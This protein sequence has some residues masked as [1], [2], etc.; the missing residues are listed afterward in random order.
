MN[1]SKETIFKNEICSYVI[2]IF[3][4]ILVVFIF[5]YKHRDEHFSKQFLLWFLAPLLLPLLI[6]LSGILNNI[7]PNRLLRLILCYLFIMIPAG[8]YIFSKANSLKIIEGR[9]KYFID[10]QQSNIGWMSSEKQIAFVGLAGTHFILYDINTKNIFIVK[11][12]DKDLLVLKPN[13]SVKK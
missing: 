11:L 12:K 10:M 3:I 4:F 5:Y 8:N 2:L 6:D 9:G 7:I 13:L 1:F